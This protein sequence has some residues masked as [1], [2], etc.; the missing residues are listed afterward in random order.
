MFLLAASTS[1]T[2][3]PKHKRLDTFKYNCEDMRFLWYNYIYE[4]L[5]VF[6][7]KLKGEFV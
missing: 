4:H 3:K 7:E 1:I 5:F 2:M 6:L